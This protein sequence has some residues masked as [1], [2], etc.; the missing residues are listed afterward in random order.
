MRVELGGNVGR[1][2]DADDGFGIEVQAIVKR[3]ED[4]SGIA[5]AEKPARAE[6]GGDFPQLAKR[7]LAVAS[8]RGKSSHEEKAPEIAKVDQMRRQASEPPMNQRER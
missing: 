6:R 2:A 7:D 3:C 4:A 8:K 5:V 1:P